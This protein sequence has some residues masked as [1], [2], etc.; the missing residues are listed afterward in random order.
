MA[1][2]LVVTMLQDLAN[3]F[4]NSQRQ[5]KAVFFFNSKFPGQ[6]VYH[7]SGV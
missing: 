7:K 6:A 2:N 1:K 5:K 4:K 3:S